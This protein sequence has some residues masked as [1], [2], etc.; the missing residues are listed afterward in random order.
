M[1]DE[2]WG[3]EMKK[4]DE[5]RDEGGLKMCQAKSGV[6]SLGGGGGG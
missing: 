3:E 4:W 5:E 6:I 1:W 2:M